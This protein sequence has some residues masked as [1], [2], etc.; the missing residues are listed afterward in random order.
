M[1]PLKFFFF[2][3]PIAVALPA[4]NGKMKT[5]SFKPKVP[6]P[7][8]QSDA[9]LATNL[10]I[11]ELLPE[12]RLEETY[13]CFL[14]SLTSNTLP[15]TARA[16][17][18]EN[19]QLLK[20]ALD[21][22]RPESRRL[23]HSLGEASQPFPPPADPLPAPPKSDPAIYFSD[24]SLTQGE[25]A[26]VIELFESSSLFEGNVMSNGRAFVDYGA[27]YRWEYDV[28]GN[29]DSPSPTEWLAVDRRM[30]GIIVKELARY[31]AV[32]PILRT[33]K[34]PLGEEGFRMIRYTPFNASSDPTVQQHTYHVDGG[35]EPLGA[36]PRV[37]AA[38]IFLSAPELGGETLFYNQGMA[39]APKCGRVLIFPSAFPYVHAGRPVERGKKYAITLMITL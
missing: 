29:P 16:S 28:S 27:K 26:S 13:A 11:S 18:E 14:Y 2:L 24:G 33:L 1:T 9:I 30:V 17:V 20:G 37:L 12:G 31:E 15:D 5:R 35:Q 38:I 7:Y 22:W 25:C 4:K 3:F 10:A 34:N 39:V 23:I 36:R 6:C 21:P 8:A 32:N 19:A